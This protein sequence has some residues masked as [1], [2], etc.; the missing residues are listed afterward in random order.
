MKAS[1]TLSSLHLSC[2]FFLC[3]L[4]KHVALDWNT[5]LQAYTEPSSQ[6]MRKWNVERRCAA[7]ANGTKYPIISCLPGFQARANVHLI[8][9]AYIG[10]CRTTCSSHFPMLVKRVSIGIS[11]QVCKVSLAKLRSRCGLDLV[12]KRSRRSPN[13]CYPTRATYRPH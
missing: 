11:P 7:T 6:T 5:K 3:H 12:G 4:C 2:I 9:S 13:Y 10:P 8:W 1:T